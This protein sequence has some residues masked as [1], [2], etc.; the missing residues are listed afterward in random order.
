M[1]RM[2]EHKPH[3]MSAEVDPVTFTKGGAKLSGAASKVV[4]ST[5]SLLLHPKV[6]HA[7]NRTV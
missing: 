4:V 7:C 6:V 1:N 5:K 3:D 2:C